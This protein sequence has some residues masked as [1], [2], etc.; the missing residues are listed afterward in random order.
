MQTDAK[1]QLHRADLG[2][3]TG[4]I[5]IDIGDEARC[6]RPDQDAGEQVAHQQRHLD[7][8]RDVAETTIAKPNAAAIVEIRVTL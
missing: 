7:A 6:C 4:Q 8:R 2:E 1:H 5:D 3:L